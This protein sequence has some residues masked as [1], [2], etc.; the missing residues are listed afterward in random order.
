VITEQLQDE[1]K[2]T[3]ER[4]NNFKDSNPI[5]I[6]MQK[7]DQIR[8]LPSLLIFFVKYATHQ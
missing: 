5:V 3:L 6:T 7:S 1:K 2:T 8:P 4:E